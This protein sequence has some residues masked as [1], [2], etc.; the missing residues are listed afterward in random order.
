MT[1][2]TAMMGT[3]FMLVIFM[4]AM[5]NYSETKAGLVIAAL[6]AAMSLLTPLAGRLA[7]RVGPRPLA[8]TGALL[9][10]AGLFALGHLARSAA[11]DQVVWRAALVGAG[12]GLSLPA[13]TSA[14][15]T[16]V[17]SDR[18]GTGAGMLNTARQLGFLA[19]VAILVAVFAH[20]MHSAMNRST[21]QAQALTRAQTA[22]SPPVRRDI[23]AALNKARTID[24]TAGMSEIRK[25]AHPLAA[26]IAPRVGFV[27]GLALLQL[28]DRLEAIF[29]DQVSAAFRWPFNTAGL[30]ALL[31]AAAGALLPG[32]LRGR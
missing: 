32:R 31:G 28:K 30:A 24:A 17:P 20:T 12:L 23:V 21:D 1:V 2:D 18:R 13:L 22:L 25:I 19:G 29:G 10:A 11:V 8:V 5:M 14:G 6:P 16:A 26:V 3:A 7:D 27:E 9:A 15:M 4:V